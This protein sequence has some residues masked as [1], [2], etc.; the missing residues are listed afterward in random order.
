MSTFDDSTD[1]VRPEKSSL[2]V[3]VIVGLGL[4]FVIAWVLFIRPAL[5]LRGSAEQLGIGK[6]LPILELQPLTGV[7]DGLS[8]KSLRGKV[9]LVNFWGTWC[10]PCLQEFP[11][12]VEL[13]DQYRGKSDFAFISVS[14]TFADREDVPAV[15]EETA[16]FLQSR[17]TTMPTYIDADG[18]TRQ[19][20]ADTFGMQGFSYP[21]TVVL[22]RN[23]II[24]GSW[25]G[26]DPSDQKQIE[27]L[28]STLLA[29]P[30]PATQNVSK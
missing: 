2:P 15:R 12:M 10:P 9:A 19:M 28:I 14:S 7:T 22:D 5:R 30:P 1:T 20:L 27:Q 23:G 11:H 3:W 26:F 8:L 18:I 13:W 29:E 4:L 24:R 25:I 17:G 16:K 21:T 6:P